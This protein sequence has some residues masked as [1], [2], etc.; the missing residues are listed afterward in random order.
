LEFGH[1]VYYEAIRFAALHER[2]GAAG[3][4]AALDRQVVQKVLPRIHGSRRRVEGALR[5]LGEYCMTLTYSVG[6]AH[7]GGQIA[8]D[9]ANARIEEAK[10][11]LSLDKVKRMMRTLQA[12]QFTSFT[13]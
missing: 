5:A 3:M 2:A 1:R 6:A 9:L 12:N 10:L 13:D 11:P 7:P 4:E 8:F